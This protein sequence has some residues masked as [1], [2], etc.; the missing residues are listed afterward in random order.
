[1]GFFIRF[2]NSSSWDST[3]RVWS[4]DQPEKSLQILKGHQAVV[5]GIVELGNHNIATASADKTIIVW[6]PDGKKV[7]TLTGEYIEMSVY[8]IYNVNFY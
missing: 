5:W 1:M 7:K 3:G 8:F 4:V 2:L 6:T